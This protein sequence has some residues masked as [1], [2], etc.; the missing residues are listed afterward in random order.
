MDATEK[1]TVVHFSHYK[2]EKMPK[3]I[4]ATGL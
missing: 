1:R 2:N 4:L 3:G